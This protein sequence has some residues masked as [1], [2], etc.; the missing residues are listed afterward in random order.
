MREKKSSTNKNLAEIF[1]QLKSKFPEDWLLSLELY[2]LALQNNY[3][4]KDEIL[5]RLAVLKLNKSYKK[6][7]ENGLVLC[8]N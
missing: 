1:I 2:E 8:K 5:E 7:I 3:V 6:L 4:I